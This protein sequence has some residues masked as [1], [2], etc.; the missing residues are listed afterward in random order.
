MDTL[1]EAKRLRSEA[2][3]QV[4]PDGGMTL[5]AWQARH[6]PLVIEGVRPAT[7]AA[8]ERGWRLR[9]QPWLGHRRIESIDVGDIDSAIAGWSGR[10][11]TR[12]DAVAVLSRLMEGA[13]RAG[14]IA[15]NPVRLARRP[16]EER[17]LSVRSRALTLAEVNTMLELVSE[18]P[19]R[20]YLAGLVFTG[21]RACEASALRVGDVDLAHGVIYVR[22]SFSP[23]G[24]G[25]VREQTPKSH[26]E[27][28]VPL[29]AALRPTVV[30]R[31]QGRGRNELVFTGPN[32]GRMSTS[33]VRR[34]VDW[35]GLRTQLDRPDLRIHDLRHT[36]ATLLFDA[37]AAA[38]DVQA[39]LGHSSMQVTER[40]SRARSDAAARANGALDRLM[41]TVGDP[42]EQIR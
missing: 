11:S 41:G 8:Y 19:Y 20:D 18:G 30:R 35:E 40:Y 16:R 5:N 39:I 34:A 14:V 23:A 2:R 36:L 26:K 4:R 33:N 24:G 10:A 27:R 7:A 17:V 22:R 29:P 1:A 9:V 37:G 15:T 21:M 31:V 38:N 6:W 25:K 3:L 12:N 32:G 42:G 28:T 13:A